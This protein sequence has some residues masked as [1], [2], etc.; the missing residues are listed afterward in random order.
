MFETLQIRMC[1]GPLVVLL[2]LL[3]AGCAGFGFG[4]GD[5]DEAA[6]ALT[7]PPAVTGGY[8]LSAI[9]SQPLPV[10][11]AQA[12]G[13]S[14]QIDGGSLALH[15]G[16]FELIRDTRRVC[17]GL[18]MA[19]TVATTRG[20]YAGTAENLRFD[21]RSGQLFQRASARIR[22]GALLL[23]PEGGDAASG[24]WRFQPAPAE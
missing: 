2:T 10:T 15:Q 23:S 7:P 5:E 4:F 20:V 19:R 1:R 17:D 8:R 24:R 18:V 16:R 21:A 11:V 3:L 22:D 9:G 6:P 13:C 14:T 12:G